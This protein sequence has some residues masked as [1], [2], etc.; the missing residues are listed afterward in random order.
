M[1]HA[2]KTKTSFFIPLA[3]LF[4]WALAPVAGHAYV[5]VELQSSRHVVGASYVVDG[6]KLIVYRP[7]GAV[8]VN[9]HAVRSIHER[10]GELSSDRQNP[11]VSP[12]TA[13]KVAANDTASSPSVEDPQRR[14]HELASKLMQMRIERLAAKQRRDQESM[15]KIDKEISQLQGERNT[16]WKKLHSEE[17][18]SGD[19]K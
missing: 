3:A 2:V 6:D 4:T 7:S 10:D 11:A 19:S 18:S 1:E 15:E 17:A 5:D 9:R 16:N 14:D 12:S 8:E 13:T